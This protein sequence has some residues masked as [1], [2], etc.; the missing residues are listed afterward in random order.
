M[1]VFPEEAIDHA[2]QRA[3]KGRWSVGPLFDERVRKLVRIGARKNLWALI[4]E[5]I[6][7][8]LKIGRRRNDRSRPQADQPLC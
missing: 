1:E 3:A 5:M 2:L 4:E 6:T 7:T 8:A